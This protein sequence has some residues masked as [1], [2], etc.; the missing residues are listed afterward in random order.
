LQLCYEGGD[1]RCPGEAGEHCDQQSCGEAWH[2]YQQ[3]Q[4]QG[5]DDR[6]DASRREQLPVAV[7]ANA[8]VFNAPHLLQIQSA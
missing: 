7:R 6:A 3:S 8:S 5:A 1:H 4:G 2:H